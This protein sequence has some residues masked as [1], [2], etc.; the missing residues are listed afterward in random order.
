VI[1]VTSLLPK[2]AIEVVNFK[3]VSLTGHA[4]WYQGFSQAKGSLIGLVSVS[5]S[6]EPILI[7]TDLIERVPKK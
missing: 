7:L 2:V 6:L 4:A 1:K 3:G 5:F